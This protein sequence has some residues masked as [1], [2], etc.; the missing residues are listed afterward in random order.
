MVDFIIVGRGLA[1][2]TLMHA[3]H[4]A[5]ISFMAVGNGT[6]S[7]CSRVAAG[8]WNPVVFKRMNPS[9]MA[10][11][12][13]TSLME[14]YGYCEK[15]LAHRLITLRQIV[16]PFSEEQEKRLWQKKATGELEPFLVETVQYNT[17][18]LEGL[19]IPDGYGLVENAGNLDVKTFID[20]T[21]TFFKE[22]IHDEIFSHAELSVGDQ[23]VRYREL[24]AG[25]IVFCEGHL[26]RHNPFFRWLPLAPAKGEL[27]TL[28]SEDIHLKRRV[29]SR[30]GFLMDLDDHRFVLGA[31]FE[32]DRL[33]EAP[34]EEGLAE[35]KQTMRRMTLQPWSV[36]EHL[37]GIRP[38]TSDRRP[39]VGRHPSHS[40]L[41]VFNGL[42]TRGVMLAPFLAGKFVLFFLKNEQLVPEADVS[43]FYRLYERV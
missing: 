39:F 17:A 28:R 5:D 2:C 22:R 1:A 10:S 25:N 21:T 29:L 41:Y 42:G 4:R 7:S 31:T 14:F 24:R 33:D 20:R 19:R 12:T 6:L 15:T 11:E 26:V 36:E 34:T 37:A 3:F 27:L 9:W 32:W 30:D 18:G 16:R 23:E 8:I 38:S 40:R 35:L 43:R 13:V